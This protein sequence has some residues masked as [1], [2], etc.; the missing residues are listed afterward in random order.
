MK[1]DLGL[2][3]LES[4]PE[5]LSGRHRLFRTAVIIFALVVVGLLVYRNFIFGGNT[6]LYKD[7][8]SDS[9]NISYPYYV[10]LSDYLRKVGILS[11]SFRVGMGQSLFPNLGTVLLTPVV[12]LAS[13]AIAKALVY[14]HLLYL[15]ISGM[16]LA[17]FLAGRGLGFGSCLLGALLLSFSAYMCMGSCWTFHANEV[18][19]FTFLLFAVEEAVRR[20][21]W[22]YLVLAVAI[23]GL[24]GAFHLYLCALLLCFYVPVRLVERYSWQPRVIV[25]TSLLLGGAAVLGVGL[26]AFASVDNLYALLNSPRGS[27]TIANSWTPPTLFQ[28][29]SP[30][31]YITAALRPF[32][33][34]IIGTGND[35]R[36]WQ[37]YLEAPISYCG[38][39]SLLILPQVFIGA[40]R[41]QRVLYGL[42]LGGILIPVVLPWFRY[43]FWLFRGGYYRAFSL[44]SILGVITLSVTAFSRYTERRTL[45]FWTLG[46]TLLVLLGILYLPI[47][48]M[49]ALID[50]GLRQTAVILLIV[51]AALLT[52]GRITKRPSIAAWVIVGVTTIEIIHFDH[53]TISNRPTLTKQE[54]NERVGYNDETVDA[55]REIKASDNSFFRITKPWGSGLAIYPSLNDAMVFGY[56][57]TTSYSSFNNLNYIKFL[58]AVD[59]I[60][61]SDLATDTQ[62]SKGLLG[63]PLLSTFACE[64]YVIT[65]DPVPFQMTDPYEFMKRYNDIYVF[66]NR[67]FLPLGLTFSRYLPEEVFLALPS[68]VKPGALLQAVVLGDRSIADEHGISELTFAE[69][70]QQLNTSTPAETI[71][72]LRSSALEM[73]SF[74]ETQIEGTV[75]VNAKSILVLQTPFDPGWRA[76]VDNRA[77]PVIKVD[78]G[79]L[80]VALSAGEHTVQLRYL[81]P[82]LAIG[83]S[84]TLGS[85]AILAVLLW[86]WPRV[87]LPA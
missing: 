1:F 3:R 7:V 67:L 14:E 26:C 12:W 35:F 25:R 83:T 34:D 8:G 27:G 18:V 9:I 10:L 11:W 40:T 63:Y 75:R 15:V 21:R 65:N 36:G 16:L 61:G 82:Y 28:F 87:A 69:L 53:I 68:G 64:K 60:S 70:K 22:L 31:H 81:P 4:A 48:E 73:R 66:R 51:Y 54:L 62:W 85:L 84:I 72:L 17:R 86:K 13:G 44:F 39:L 38:L 32:S 49:R 43:L 33:N 77:A 5:L 20:G 45:N 71:G 41:R 57:G 56:Y 55:V 79:L 58:M 24:L 30:L 80:G 19:C 47:D 46:A 52:V 23:V 42:F 59:A 76:L 37:N 78:A 50:P 74:R 29:A 2:R 6:L